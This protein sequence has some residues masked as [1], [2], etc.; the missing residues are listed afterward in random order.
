[1][2]ANARAAVLHSSTAATLDVIEQ[3][4]A[5][6]DVDAGL[7][8]LFAWL[9]WKRR[10]ETA[11]SWSAWV[12]TC[13]LEHPLARTLHAE[14]FTAAAYFKP[15]GF[16]GDAGILDFMYAAL[17]PELQRRPPQLASPL[18]AATHA[19]IT[20]R[21]PSA[22]AVAGRCRYFAAAIDRTASRSRRAG[23]G[24]GRVLAIAAG[25]LR[26][27]F[28][29]RAVQDGTIAEVVALDQDPRAIAEIAESCAGTPVTPL[30][31]SIR[32][33]LNGSL[34]LGEFDLIYA[35][36]LFD[37]LS[38]RTAAALLVTLIGRLRPEG[39][40]VIVNFVPDH[41]D[42]G[43]MESFMDWHLTYRSAADLLALVPGE[44]AAHSVASRAWTDA[45]GSLAFLEVTLCRS[46]SVTSTLPPARSPSSSPARRS[47]CRSA[48]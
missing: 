14:P 29:S 22:R 41:P 10:S 19:Y 28:L 47:P 6:G 39:R 33:L 37:Y 32:G 46:P 24:G 18:L 1:M 44:V 21:R 34:R 9:N 48:P 30:L 2:T 27:R 25:H 11:D 35:A 31:G 36:G 38:Q 20:T 26:E 16:A 5:A 13:A 23:G 8:Q 40:L 45:T 4:L 12:R 42:L 3:R 17:L 15:R 7:E 43:Y